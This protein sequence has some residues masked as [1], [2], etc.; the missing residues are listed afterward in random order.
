MKRRFS[1]DL[2]EGQVAPTTSNREV[3]TKL[4]RLALLYAAEEPENI[5]LVRLYRD[6]I[7]S[8]ALTPNENAL[9]LIAPPEERWVLQLGYRRLDEAW[10]DAETSR[11]THRSVSSSTNGSSPL[12]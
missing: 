7:K 4:S 11:L 9:R 3:L 2:Q 1:R 8:G 6:Q 10:V 12:T 5:A